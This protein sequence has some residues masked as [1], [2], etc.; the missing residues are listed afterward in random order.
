MKIK[1]IGFDV[2][3]TLIDYN[4]PLNWSSLYKPAII[5]MLNECNLAFSENRI[6][7]AISTLLKYNTRI[8][9]REVE[10]SSD[11]IFSEIFDK[12]G[13]DKSV[14]ESSKTSFY[15]FFQASAKPFDDT[16][17]MLR[18]LKEIGYKIGILTD[19]AYGMDNKFSRLDIQSIEKYIDV[20]LSSIDVGYRKPNS[21]AFIGLSNALGVQAIDMIFI[22]DEE[23]DIKGANQVG[24]NSVLINRTDKFKD[25]GQQY[26]ITS[27]AELEQL[28][29]V[30]A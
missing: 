19:V 30:E 27:L 22:G 15:S 3:H 11:I 17:P 25:Y 1:A 7:E 26:T 18:K 9:Y 20:Y 13:E 23:K 10:C 6:E 14:M 8:N 5:K 12:W 21:K 28:L 16:E 4:N 29:K 24:M 2:G